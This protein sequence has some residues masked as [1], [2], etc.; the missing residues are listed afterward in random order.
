MIKNMKY[1]QTSHLDN[2]MTN[3]MNLSMEKLACTF[4]VTMSGSF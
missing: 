4:L 1:G 3:I 2:Y